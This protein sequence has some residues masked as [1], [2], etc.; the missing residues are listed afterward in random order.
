ML[1]GYSAW[2]LLASDM[3]DATGVA[4]WR[5]G[6]MSLT[7]YGGMLLAPLPLLW[8]AGVAGVAVFDL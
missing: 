1:C 5:N 2:L 4:F 8:G 3:S 7:Y 6:I